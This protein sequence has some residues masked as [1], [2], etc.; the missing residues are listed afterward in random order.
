MVN[1]KT[2]AK[3]LDTSKT[4]S[5]KKED[6]L[7]VKKKRK[8]RLF[9]FT[10]LDGKRYRITKKQ[11]AFADYWLDLRTTGTQAAIKAG[12]GMKKGIVDRNVAATIASQNLGKLNIINYI[13]WRF[14]ECGLTDELVEK[15]HLITLTQLRDLG[16]KNRA[17]D[18][19]YKLRGKYA[20]EKHKHEIGVD[21]RMTK[22]LDRV[23][24][25]FPK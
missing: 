5:K 3:L 6:K 4:D 8:P 16:V 17:I 9:S 7:V 1:G 20:A 10:G 22:F 2:K 19:F 18:M 15:H 24:K 21:E 13:S 11:K 23:S 12:Y 14:K 25:R